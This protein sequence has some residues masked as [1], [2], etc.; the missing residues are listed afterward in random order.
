[1]ADVVEKVD[2]VEVYWMPGCTACLRL[3]EFV[4][5]SGRDYLPINIDEDKAGAEKLTLLGVHVPAACV[6]ERCVNGLDLE[7]VAELIGVPYEAPV[8]LSPAELVAKYVIINEAFRRFLVQMPQEGLSLKLP[9]RDR[10]IL[11]VADQTATVM[12]AF[13]DAYEG[14]YHSSDY[15]PVPDDVKTPYDLVRRANVTLQ[16]FLE[17]WENDGID[18]PL[19]RVLPTAWGHRTLHEVLERE[20]WHTAQHTRQIQ[21]ALEEELHIEPN[22]RL[23]AE[24]LAGLPLPERVHG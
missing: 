20:V 22:G 3:K 19:D 10:T 18:D 11:A 8:I 15:W 5:K 13:L 23:T 14:T 1:M 21:F 7:G 16:M 12:R 6:G 4:E 2:L 9:H 17:W 24:D